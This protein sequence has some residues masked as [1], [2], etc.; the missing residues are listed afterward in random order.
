LPGGDA[1][2]D[3]DTWDAGA[4]ARARVGEERHER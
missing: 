1:A 3:C 2:L 4:R